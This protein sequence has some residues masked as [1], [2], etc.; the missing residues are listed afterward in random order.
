VIES[1]NLWIFNVGNGCRFTSIEPQSP[2]KTGM[3]EMIMKRFF[4]LLP[5]V[6]C[7]KF[8]FCY[9]L[10]AQPIP[11]VQSHFFEGNAIKGTTTPVTP[12]KIIDTIASSNWKATTKINANKGKFEPKASHPGNTTAW[13][14]MDPVYD[15]TEEKALF[16][17]IIMNPPSTNVPPA[18]QYETFFQGKFKKV[19]SDGKGVFRPVP[20]SEWQVDLELEDSDSNKPFVGIL[21]DTHAIEDSRSFIVNNNAVN[22]H[23]SIRFACNRPQGTGEAIKV[24]FKI[25][26]ANTSKLGLHWK[27]FHSVTTQ[28]SSRDNIFYP[29]GVVSA[30]TND[31][32]E[33]DIPAG[34]QCSEIFSMSAVA[35]GNYF[36]QSV[37]LKTDAYFMEKTS[38][39]VIRNTTENK[40]M[41][42]DF[43]TTVLNGT[44]QYAQGT[45]QLTVI[46]GVT[47]FGSSN[48]DSDFEDHNSDGI[49]I[50]D[51][52]QGSI[53]DCYFAVV[54]MAL[55]DKNPGL[56]QQL[57]IENSNHTLF[58]VNAYTETGASDPYVFDLSAED[59]SNQIFLNGDFALRIT[60]D[61]ARINLPL[62]AGRLEIWPQL[63][64]RAWVRKCGSPL[65][66][67]GGNAAAPWKFLTNKTVTLVSCTGKTNDEVFDMLVAGTNSNNF[68]GI[69]IGTKNIMSD[70]IANEYNRYGFMAKHAY[71]VS[72]VLPTDSTIFLQNPWRRN[73]VKLSKSDLVEAIEI[74]FILTK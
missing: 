49:D 27:D 68:C 64:E 74:F 8:V 18:K 35:D 5:F 25:S 6:I 19:V 16:T 34:E 33:I 23:I 42:G 36:A 12:G 67:V 38:I 30:I 73:N 24:R 9:Q 32:Y 48:E 56:L 17:S 2:A 66:T 7:I 51:V 41:P 29:S 28:A 26:W 10:I 61:Y 53:G 71:Y 40:Y 1:C 63:C 37:G 43:E 65:N 54:L 47:R 15:T 13:R 3:G 69:Y 21:G 22:D 58:T 57:I 44:G 31:T 60:G 52:Q 59:P 39:S 72:S 46:D 55:A 70:H 4:V 20:T 11:P 62:L 50:N 45:M 14:I